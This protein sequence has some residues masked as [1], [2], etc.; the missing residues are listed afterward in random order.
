MTAFNPAHSQRGAKLQPW[1]TKPIFMSR[2]RCHQRRQGQQRVDPREL[3]NSASSAAPSVGT[4]PTLVSLLRS[5]P[6]RASEFRAAAK[7]RDAPDRARPGLQIG[8]TAA[9]SML[10][11]RPAPRLTLELPS[12]PYLPDGGL[13]E[14][15]ISTGEGGC[16]RRSPDADVRHADRQARRLTYRTWTRWRSVRFLP[17]T[18]RTALSRRFL[19]RRGC[20][21]TGF[22]RTPIKDSGLL[23]G[24]VALT[25]H[26]IWRRECGRWTRTPQGSR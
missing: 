19:H 23:C 8:C 24:A 11:R 14:R 7:G 13:S 9:I 18:A 26:M 22:W 15:R 21:S 12:F 6:A 16:R 2:Y 4:S 3:L 17:G 1:A 25:Q 5:A 10:R 20:N